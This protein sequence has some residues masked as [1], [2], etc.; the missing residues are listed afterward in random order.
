MEA[1]V[2]EANNAISKYKDAYEANKKKDN[3]E[4]ELRIFKEKIE[5]EKLRAF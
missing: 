1:L 2:R 4:E 3:N 5:K